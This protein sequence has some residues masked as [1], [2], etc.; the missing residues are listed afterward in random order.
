MSL[1][2]FTATRIVRSLYLVIALL[3]MAVGYLI[4][5]ASEQKQLTQLNRLQLRSAQHQQNLKRLSKPTAEPPEPVAFAWQLSRWVDEFGLTLSLQPINQDKSTIS[6]VVNGPTDT[7]QQL[8]RR[9][10]SQS[11]DGGWKQPLR[12]QVLS[13]SRESGNEV[14]RLNWQLTSADTQT[15]L[16]PLMISKPVS[17]A[18]CSSPFDQAPA[19]TLELTHL[20]LAAIVMAKGSHPYA[21]WQSA[22]GHYIKTTIGQ[23]FSN[24]E[25]IITDIGPGH[26][27]LNQSLP[28]DSCP[29]TEKKVITL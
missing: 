20:R 11:V 25:S 12:S 9:T 19:A 14:S 7:L 1:S 8:L 15:V 13:I 4:T 21:Y 28:T 22:S 29:I 26:V 3:A 5:H 16:K 27:E 2:F 23:R 24:P 18:D 17:G 6:I 10:S